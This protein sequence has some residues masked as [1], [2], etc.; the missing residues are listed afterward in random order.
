MNTQEKTYITATELSEKLG[1]S[2][3][4]AYKIIREL[5]ADLKKQGYITVAGKCP[6]RYIEKKWYGFGV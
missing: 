5:N 2:V 1:I 6:R 3:G 4:Q